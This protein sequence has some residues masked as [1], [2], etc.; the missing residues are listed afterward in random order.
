MTPLRQRFTEDMQ[1][2]GLAPTR[3][4]ILPI[5]CDLSIAIHRPRQITQKA[6]LLVRPRLLWPLPRL[7]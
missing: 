3:S 2:C 4:P 7:S 1:L 5:P 6:T